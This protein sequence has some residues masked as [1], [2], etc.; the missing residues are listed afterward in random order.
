MTSYL[1][2]RSL[3]LFTLAR[4]VTKLREIV[5]FLAGTVSAAFENTFCCRLVT[6]V[7]T[8]VREW[9]AVACT[10]CVNIIKAARSV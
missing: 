5:P 10:V 3:K 4:I 6:E 1:R 2:S 9:Y 7:V 8:C